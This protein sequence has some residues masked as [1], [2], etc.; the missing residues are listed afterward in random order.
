MLPLWKRNLPLHIFSYCLS[1]RNDENVPESWI[2]DQRRLTKK[3]TVF[4]IRF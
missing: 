4:Y 1:I 3:N 2:S